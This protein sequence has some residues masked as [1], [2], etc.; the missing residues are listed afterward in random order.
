[1]WAVYKGFFKC[2]APNQAQYEM[3]KPSGNPYEM[4]GKNK[5]SLFKGNPS[6]FGHLYGMPHP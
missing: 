6:L 5:K 1:M 2:V 3:H 4:L